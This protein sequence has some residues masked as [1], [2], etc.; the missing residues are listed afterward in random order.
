MD[1]RRTTTQSPVFARR[2]GPSSDGAQDFAIAQRL[3]FAGWLRNGRLAKGLTLV[4]VAAITKIQGRTLEL[5][6]AG[7][8]DELPAD[9][10]LRGFVRNYA[11]CVGLSADEA[12]RRY[13]EC[14]KAPGPV[15]A[16]RAFASVMTPPPVG[17][18]GASSAEL[19]PLSD[20]LLESDPTDHSARTISRSVRVAAGSEVTGV[21]E[22]TTII[23]KLGATLAESVANTAP[24]SRAEE[25]VA[26]L[27]QV[28]EQA[29][30]HTEQVTREDL[31]ADETALDFDDK[32]NAE[33]QMT[34]DFSAPVSAPDDESAAPMAP[35]VAEV[36]VPMAVAATVEPVASVVEDDRGLFAD[37][38]GFRSNS[39]ALLRPIESMGELMPSRMAAGSDTA[40]PAIDVDAASSRVAM[41]AVK[42]APQPVV[43]VAAA[44]S[45]SIV[46]TNRRFRRASTA[47][48]IRLTIDDADPTDAEQL[49]EHRASE[50]AGEASALRERARRSFLP[51]VLLDN[52]RSGRQ[53]GLTLAVIIL[54]IAAT[55]TLS[56]LMRRPGAGGDGITV[57]DTTS[58]LRA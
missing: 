19:P 18:A 33:L 56:Y 16:A 12:M 9:V 32:T 42:P 52:D 36:V 35:I 14:G 13:T 58:L 4:E 45:G 1:R 17:G 3:A 48:P 28:W 22:P 7:E 55:L 50:Q 37:R 21:A 10:F 5:L 38:T 51:P 27:L 44:A 34:L 53:G 6:E 54:L 11:R 23:G 40:M 46:R 20:E 30:D 49:Q 15:A 26:S 2:G 25:T 47:A 31:T 57:R 41:L 8:F 29:A 39:R 43:V 24:R